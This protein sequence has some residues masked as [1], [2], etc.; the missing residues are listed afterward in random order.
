M[1][2]TWCF[3]HANILKGWRTEIFAPFFFSSLA[4]PYYIEQI[5]Y[6]SCIYS[7]PNHVIFRFE[8]SILLS[9]RGER[10]RLVCLQRLGFLLMNIRRDVVKGIAQSIM[11]LSIGD[12]ISLTAKICVLNICLIQHFAINIYS[13]QGITEKLVIS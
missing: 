12:R 7:N 11:A 6:I 13:N 9:H 1:L 8:K 4:K 3:C 2:M 10:L 5:L